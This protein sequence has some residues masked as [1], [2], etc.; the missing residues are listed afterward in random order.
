MCTPSRCSCIRV[1]VL[2]P[3]PAARDCPH[4][5]LRYTA[6]GYRVA[7]ITKDPQ[8]YPRRRKRDGAACIQAACSFVVMAM[9]HCA[10]RRCTN[11]HTHPPRPIS[12]HRGTPKTQSSLGHDG[13]AQ[14][15]CQVLTAGDMGGKAP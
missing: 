6:L 15:R 1:T 12:E 11:T 3:L 2:P 8:R 14:G 9:V 4:P 7:N 10:G 5:V 13:G